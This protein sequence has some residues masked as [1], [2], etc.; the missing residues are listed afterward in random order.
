MTSAGSVC[1]GPLTDHSLLSR[2]KG[3]PEEVN[4]Y[5]LCEAREEQSHDA[6]QMELTNVTVHQED[7]VLTLSSE[8][9]RSEYDAADLDAKKGMALD[10]V[11]VN[12]TRLLQ[13]RRKLEEVGEKDGFSFAEIFSDY[14]HLELSGDQFMEICT[15]ELMC[16]PCSWFSTE[17][18][19]AE[20]IEHLIRNGPNTGHL[21]LGRALLL[22]AIPYTD[23]N[24]PIDAT[25]LFHICRVYVHPS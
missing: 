25:G 23:L 18:R 1:L 9:E 6:V 11:N 15:S 3:T 2:T 19:S 8:K 20:V 22:V 13:H 4:L 24:H 10:R 14:N 21:R 16:H 12:Q 5:D 17:L 7:R